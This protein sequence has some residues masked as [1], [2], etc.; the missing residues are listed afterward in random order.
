MRKVRITVIKKGFDQALVARYVKA[1]AAA[2]FK[3]CGHAIGESFVVGQPVMCPDGMCPWAWHDV[4]SFVRIA[5]FEGAVGDM[6]PENSWIRSCTDAFRPVT[7][8]IEPL[9][10]EEN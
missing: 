10:E 1:D 8:L 9:E 5:A 4:E 7:F 3:P 2:A 6:L